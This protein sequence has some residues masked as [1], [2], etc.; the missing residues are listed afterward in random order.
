MLPEVSPLSSQDEREDQQQL[1]CDT[2]PE[3]DQHL[4]GG[5]RSGIAIVHPIEISAHG[6]WTR[7]AGLNRTT[8]F[9]RNVHLSAMRD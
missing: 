1:R 8:D 9:A 2:D 6:D 4:A 5:Q 3:P 7:S